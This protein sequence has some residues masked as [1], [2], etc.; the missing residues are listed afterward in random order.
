MGSGGVGFR[1]AIV[2]GFVFR[3]DVGRRFDLA[4]PADPSTG[5]YF[6]RRFI[7][8]FFGYNY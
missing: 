4:A 7:D 2:P 5:D 6:E 1:M 8:F 3:L